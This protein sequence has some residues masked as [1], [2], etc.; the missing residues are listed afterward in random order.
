M[1]LSGI[2]FKVIWNWALQRM[3]KQYRPLL[4]SCCDCSPNWK[5]LLLSEESIDK[6]SSMFLPTPISW[7][8][9]GELWELL[10]Q[11]QMIIYHITVPIKKE[12]NLSVPHCHILMCSGLMCMDDTWIQFG[13][14]I[15]RAAVFLCFVWNFFFSPVALRHVGFYYLSIYL[16]LWW[17]HSLL[18]CS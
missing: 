4:V 5:D 7:N 16:L 12:L 18:T 14:C 6:M 9:G 10:S 11:K 8:L 1:V 13:Y 15:Y 3:M 17:A 2:V